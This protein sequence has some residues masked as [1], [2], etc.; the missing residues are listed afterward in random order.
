MQMQT[1]WNPED[2][3]RKSTGTKKINQEKGGRIEEKGDREED[4]GRGE[5][6]DDEEVVIAYACP[7]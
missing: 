3:D 2:G 5:K 1:L 6:E 7:L 4:Q